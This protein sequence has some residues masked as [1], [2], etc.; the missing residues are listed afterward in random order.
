MTAQRPIARPIA[1]S[2]PSTNVHVCPLAAIHDVVTESGASHLMTVINALTPVETP[3]LIAPDRHLKILINDI[4]TPQEGL[5]HARPEHI[6]EILRFARDWNH[7]AP[8]VVHCWAGISRSTAAAFITL[9][10]LNEEGLENDIARSIREASSTAAPNA[11]MVSIADDILGRQGQMVDAIRSIGDG[12][13]ALAGTPFFI[14][15]RF[16]R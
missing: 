7:A 4:S 6:E 8:L 3:A 13:P 15:S 2:E 12:K 1:R 9:C 5:V 11:L 10:A 14:P 16:S